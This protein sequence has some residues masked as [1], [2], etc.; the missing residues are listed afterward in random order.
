MTRAGYWAVLPADVRYDRRLTQSAKLLYAEIS[1]LAQVTGYCWATD[2]HFADMLGCSTKTVSRM[3]C[4]LKEAG[5]IWCE[6][7]AN[8]TGPERHIYCGI[9]PEKAAGGVTDKND[10]NPGDMVTD[11]HKD[12]DSGDGNPLPTQYKKN[13][14][15]ITCARTREKDDISA[16]IDRV[17]TDFSGKDT[18]LLTALREFAEDRRQRK[19]PMKTS[20]AAQMLTKKLDRLSGG[21]RAVMVLMLEKAVERGWSSV[22][23]L[24]P[25]EIPRSAATKVEEAPGVIWAEDVPHE[26]Y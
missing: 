1:S 7:T 13:N 3:I 9:A 10:H 8:A 12:M 23:E 2:R 19:A 14:K 16:Q 21:D 25:D 20:R 22:Y 6:L 26:Y 24:K 11:D 4:A 15:S 17:F 18:A 5:Y